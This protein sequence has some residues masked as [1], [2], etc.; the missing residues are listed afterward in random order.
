MY[1]GDQSGDPGDTINCRCDMIAVV[2][3]KAIL[4]RVT[5]KWEREF[6]PSGGKGT[7]SWQ[8]KQEALKAL[9]RMTMEQ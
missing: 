6:Y 1:P 5:T 7:E 2:S 9:E 3:Q 4:E 8:R